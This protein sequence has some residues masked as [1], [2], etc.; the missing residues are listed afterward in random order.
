MRIISDFQK[1][2]QS[3]K[4]NP[5][6][7][8][9][10][11]FDACTDDG[12]AL[13]IIFYDG[14]PFSRKYIKALSDKRDTVT[15][16]DFPAISISLYKDG[17][18]VFYSFEEFQPEQAEF[19]TTV[20]EGK[21]GE[22]QFYGRMEGDILKYRVSLN[23]SVPNGDSIKANLI[24]TS[25]PFDLSPISQQSSSDHK[26]HTWNLVMPRGEVEGEIFLKGYCEKEIR[27][28]GTGYHDHNT[29]S[30]PMKESFNEWYWGRYHTVDSTLVY[31]LMFEKGEWQKKAWLIE[32]N[33]Q[34][35]EMQGNV[36]MSNRGL[37]KFA[38]QPARTL[39]F[40]GEGTEAFLQ[41]ENVVDD[42]P[43]YQRYLGQMLINKGGNILRAGGI[44]E[45]IYPSR[46]Y[47]KIFWPLVDMR[48]KY[49]GKAHWV[50]KNP[51]LYRWTW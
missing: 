36:E 10:W 12:Y 24:F 5:G 32:N 15:A 37:S 14:N 30:E 26:L 38:L 22:N 44:S 2:T 39:Q 29:G 42:G 47:S 13:V 16:S 8:E 18:P 4:P 41:L 45:Y 43:F 7:Y 51:K 48:I 1:D 25:R 6:S 23:Q 9:W 27:F 50:Q 17:E 40:K 3:D 19:S 46:I 11:Y 31:Y 35:L 33:G 34:I 21:V 49:P 28:R 20:P